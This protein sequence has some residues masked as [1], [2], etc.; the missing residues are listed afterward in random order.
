MIK[1]ASTFGWQYVLAQGLVPRQRDQ[2]GAGA[3]EGA[4]P[5]REGGERSRRISGMYMLRAGH[6]ALLINERFFS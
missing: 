4:Q 1:S 6:L 2:D 3:A 5:G